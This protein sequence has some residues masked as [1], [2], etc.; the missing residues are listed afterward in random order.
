MK[1]HFTRPYFSSS[2][3][4]GVEYPRLHLGGQGGVHWQNDQLRYLRTKALHALKQDL[5]GRINL[6]L[7][8]VCDSHNDMTVT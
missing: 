7:T 2:R 4:G 1:W 3:R 5:T 8:W 6:L